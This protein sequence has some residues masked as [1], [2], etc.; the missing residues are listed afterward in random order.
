MD[1]PG[2]RQVPEVGGDQGKWRKLVAK[3]SVCPNDPRG[4]GIDENDEHKT[5]GDL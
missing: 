3:L 1:R 2:V 4:Q 5:R